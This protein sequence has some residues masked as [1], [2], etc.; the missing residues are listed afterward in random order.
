MP[1]P[2]RAPGSS[3]T[4]E[5]LT[6]VADHHEPLHAKVPLLQMPGGLLQLIDRAPLAEPLTGD[7]CVRRL[8]RQG[9]D[10]PDPHLLEQV[11]QFVGHERRHQALGHLEA[12][13]EIGLDEEAQKALE[14]SSAL[15]QIRL[16]QHDGADAVPLAQV[17]DLLDGVPRIAGPD[18]MAF[19]QGHRAVGGPSSGA[20]GPPVVGRASR[21]GS[22][23]LRLGAILQMAQRVGWTAGP[24]ESSSSRWR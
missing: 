14:V 11:G 18:A 8:E 23:H 10:V 15:E 7:L 13:V 20:A 5:P 9:Y 21:A 3:S 16:P 24:R 4:V 19:Q 2:T 22:R 1:S 12:H 17:P 6:A